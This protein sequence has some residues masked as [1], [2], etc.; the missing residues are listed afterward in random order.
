MNPAAPPRVESTLEILDIAT[1]ARRVVFRAATHIEAPNWS[2]DGKFFV[3]NSEGR[4]YRLGRDGGE[5]VRIDTWPLHRLNN[6]HGLSPGGSLIAVSDQSTADGLSRIHVLHIDGRVPR[7]ITEEAPSYWHGWSPD[8]LTL[9]YVAARG[10]GKDLNIYTVPAAGGAERR[11]T[12]APGLDDGPDYSP[13]GQFIYFNSMRSGNMKLWRMRADGGAPEQ[14]T[15]ED[16]TRDWFPHP[17]PDGKWIVFLSFGVDV[18]VRDHPANK[19]VTLRLMPASGGAPQT[20]ASLFGGQG[21]MNVPSWSPDGK[22]FA[23][24]S[25]RLAG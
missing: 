12:D 19:N 7:L 22:Q 25:Y 6:D 23:F 1:N 8:G 9:A 5:P 20:I 2:R 10:G 17:S 16:D 21:T 4:L 3:F 15:F 24:V 13:D 11:L 14:L 18:Q